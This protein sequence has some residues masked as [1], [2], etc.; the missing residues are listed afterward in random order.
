MELFTIPAGNYLVFKYQ[1]SAQGFPQFW[2]H[3]HGDWL[4]N[5]EFEL[6]NRPHFEK[7]PEGYNP[8]D[9]NAKE[10]VWVPVK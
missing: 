6:D 9:S 10:E 2:Q 3:L 7:L 1:G 8:M 5:S 4:P